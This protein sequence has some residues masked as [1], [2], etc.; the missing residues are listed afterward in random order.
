MI[1]KQKDGI[2]PAVSLPLKVGLLAVGAFFQYNRVWNL[3]S[4]YD[5][6]YYW[7]VAGY[8]WLDHPLL[9]VI[10]RVSPYE[11]EP[12]FEPAEV[13]GEIAGSGR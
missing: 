4:F 11:F 10:L 12:F 1:I 5:R 8:M 9:G 2:W 7:K 3:N 13:S 6:I